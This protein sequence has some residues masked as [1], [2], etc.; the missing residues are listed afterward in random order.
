MSSTR[1]GEDDKPEEQMLVSY[2]ANN[3][4]IAFIKEKQGVH[5][6]VIERGDVATVD[7]RNNS[8]TLN[9]LKEKTNGFTDM[10]IG[11]THARCFYRKCIRQYGFKKG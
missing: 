3:R 10:K 1:L 6:L 11:L 2:D 9:M 8:P 4:Q 5:Y 7:A